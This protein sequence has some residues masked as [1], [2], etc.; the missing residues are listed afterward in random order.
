MGSERRR[1]VRSWLVPRMDEPLPQ[2]LYRLAGKIRVWVLLVLWFLNLTPLYGPNWAEID[3][4]FWMRLHAANSAIL[5]FDVLLGL[6]AWRGNLSLANLRRVTWVC[7]FLDI[8]STMLVTWGFGSVSTHMGAF[9]IVVV[10][11]Y[12][13]GMDFRMGSAALICVVAGQWARPLTRRRGQ[14]LN[15]LYQAAAR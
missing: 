1:A 13:A 6:L 12:R 9:A 2:E 10:L 14:K 11:I 4:E 15:R 8:A 3:R 5:L 7:M